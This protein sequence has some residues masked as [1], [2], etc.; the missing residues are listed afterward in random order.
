LKPQ[1]VIVGAGGHAKVIIDILEQRGELR[2]A[3]CTSAEN[4]PREV[5][6]YPV[7]GSDDCLPA[8]F[9]S[10]V[11][12]AI[13]AIGDNRVREEKM[14]CLSELG[15]ELVNAVS[16]HAT[17]SPRAMAATASSMA[18]SFELRGVVTGDMP[19]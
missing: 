18:A 4:E 6:G 9:S 3:G 19:P 7:L 13:A 1:V 14:S 10:G 5:L 2:I 15:F 11:S 12:F 16:P 17:I 8:L